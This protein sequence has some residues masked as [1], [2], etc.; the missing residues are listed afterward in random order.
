MRFAKPL[1]MAVFSLAALGGS[2]YAQESP[3]LVRARA[4]RIDPADKS[5]PVP[6]LAVPA[7]AI[8]V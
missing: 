2:C 4:L 5:D 7:D 3:W 6:T 8:R 1:A